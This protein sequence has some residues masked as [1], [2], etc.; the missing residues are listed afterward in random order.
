MRTRPVGVLILAALTAGLP[1]KVAPASASQSDSPGQVSGPV[2]LLMLPEELDQLGRISSAGEQQAF[3]EWFWERR[4]PEPEGPRNEFRHEY[5][6][7][8]AFVDKEFGEGP[9]SPGWATGR[10]RIYLLMGPPQA[11]FVTSRRFYVDHALRAL[12]VWQYQDRRTLGRIVRFAFVTTESGTKLA[13]AQG[14][15]GLAPEQNDSLRQARELLVRDP[16]AGRFGIVDYRDAGPLPLQAELTTNGDGIMASLQLPLN[17][18]LGEPHGDQIRYRFRIVALR[19]AAGMRPESSDLMEIDIGPEEF[20][21]WSDQMLHIAVWL[22]SGSDSIR[23]IEEPTGRTATVRMQASAPG[24]TRAIGVRLAMTP[25]LG[26]R[27][28]AVAYFPVCPD[29]HPRAE[30]VLVDAADPDAIVIEPLPG[31]RLALAMPPGEGR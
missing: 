17:Q 20:R 11:N 19:T 28:V 4:N 22:P 13:I 16:S 24:G 31:G 6:D 30:A 14:D 29:R 27:G 2:R 5:L 10:G 26:G 25:L 15:S 18:L 12:T 7:R 9:H 8:V 1:A 3:I 23:V 21:T